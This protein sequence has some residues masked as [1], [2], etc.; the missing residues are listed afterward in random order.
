MCLPQN[1]DDGDHMW[2]DAFEN[3]KWKCHIHLSGCGKQNRML[4]A[5]K[6]DTCDFWA[7]N[8]VRVNQP[9]CMHRT[10]F[11][12][13]SESSNPSAHVNHHSSESI[14]HIH[15]KCHSSVKIWHKTIIISHYVA[16][17]MCHCR[18]RRKEPIS[19]QCWR[20]RDGQN[21]GEN[22]VPPPK[23]YATQNANAMAEIKNNFVY[24]FT[25]KWPFTD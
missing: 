20:R 16:T 8:F 2:I 21:I 5:E 25:I 19:F 6:W 13:V 17:N 14:G 4:D 11:G 3:V 24:W 22:P 1:C 7:C 12:V 18:C 10:A 9:F 23:H 15:S